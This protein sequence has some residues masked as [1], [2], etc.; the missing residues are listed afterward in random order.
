MVRN[1]LYIVVEVRHRL[2]TDTTA[3]VRH[4]EVVAVAVH[5]IVADRRVRDRVPVAVIVEVTHLQAEVHA[6]PI[7]VEETLVADSF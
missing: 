3:E 4:I 1:S 6:H 2:P 5:H 7:R